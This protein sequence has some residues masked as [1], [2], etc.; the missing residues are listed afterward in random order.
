MSL[1]SY[2]GVFLNVPREQT[3]QQLAD[4]RAGLRRKVLASPLFDARRFARHFEAALWGMW[5]ARGER[6]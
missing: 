2:L 6:T 1:P 4:L 3:L 5:Q